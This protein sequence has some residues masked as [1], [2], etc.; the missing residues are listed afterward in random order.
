VNTLLA[1]LIVNV[2][3]IVGLLVWMKHPGPPIR[4]L[5]PAPSY[6]FV[7]LFGAAYNAVI[8]RSWWGT[9]FC[10]GLAVVFRLGRW[11]S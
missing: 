7:A 6:V 1:V 8:V 10:L 11:M 9:A 2:T 3:A 4:G 5:P